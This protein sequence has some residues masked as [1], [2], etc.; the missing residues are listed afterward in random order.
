MEVD[1]EEIIAKLEMGD[2]FG[3]AAVMNNTTRMATIS[4]ESEYR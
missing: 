1:E 3:E 4:A 2:M